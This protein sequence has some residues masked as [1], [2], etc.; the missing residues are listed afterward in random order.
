MSD[1][2]LLTGGLG[3]VGGRISRHLAD[4][5]DYQL[6]IGSRDASQPKPDWLSRGEIVALDL[7]DEASL[8]AACRGVKCVIHLAALN[9][10]DSAANPERSLEVN[11]L[12]SL[13][14]L[15]AAISAGVERFIYFSTAHVYGSPLAGTLTEESLPRPQH[16]YAITHRT[17]EDFVL[18]ARDKN[19]IDGI[20]VRLSNG[21]G[22]PERAEVDRWSLLANDLC[23]QAVTAKKMVLRSAGLQYRDFITLTDVSRGVLHLLNLAP[24]ACG[25]GLFNLG[26]DAPL[27]IIEVVEKV[28]D[29]CDAVLGFRPEIQRP[30]ISADE[31]VLTLEYRMDKLKNTGFSLV[32][33]IDEEIEATLRLCQQAFGREG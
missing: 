19:E 33:N 25:N 5:S 30:P 23:R 3:Y 27:R 15:R 4:T 18:A 13:K 14:L 2:I 24:G 6:R 20:V 29:R 12:G 11:G 28:A 8:A 31:K 21:F 9:E 32:S 10:I 17:A 1:M 7:L 16:P 22:V 26:G